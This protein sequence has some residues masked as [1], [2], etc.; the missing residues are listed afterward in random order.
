MRPRRSRRY[1][2]VERLPQRSLLLP[3]FGPH[4]PC[5]ELFSGVPTLRV[6]GLRSSGGFSSGACVGPAGGGACSH[7]KNFRFQLSLLFIDGQR[8]GSSSVPQ[9]SNSC[10]MLWPD[11]YAGHRALLL[12]LFGFASRVARLCAAMSENPHKKEIPA[13]V[14][15]M[16]RAIAKVCPSIYLIP[17]PVQAGTIAHGLGRCGCRSS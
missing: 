16:I 15:A 7:S 14:G 3:S 8:P 10:R 4:G 12:P 2:I 17:C 6:P 1:G 9:Q 11:A 13:M 5:L